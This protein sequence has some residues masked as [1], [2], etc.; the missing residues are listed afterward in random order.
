MGQAKEAMGRL[1]AAINREAEGGDWL[2]VRR[3]ALSTAPMYLSALRGLVRGQPAAEPLEVAL[4]HRLLANATRDNG[5]SAAKGVVSAIRLLEKI[6]A[7]PE[8]IRPR[9][10]LQV[11]AVWRK[12]AR[13]ES[14]QVWATALYVEEMG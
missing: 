5:G 9:H 13:N 12:T 10:W 14:P 1:Y 8:T 6:G 7:V 2:A 11:S 4:E 3:V